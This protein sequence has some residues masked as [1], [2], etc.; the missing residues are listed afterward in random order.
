MKEEL[1]TK[2][3]SFTFQITLEVVLVD[4]TPRSLPTGCAYSQLSHLC[5]PLAYGSDMVV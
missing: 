2:N 4:D 1:T 5:H 3:V